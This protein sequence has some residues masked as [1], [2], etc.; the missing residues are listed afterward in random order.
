VSKPNPQFVTVR[1]MLLGFSM[2]KESGYDPARTSS[3]P[4]DLTE[5]DFQKLAR[6]GFWAPFS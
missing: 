4:V 1:W 6:K 3:V 2:T 5:I